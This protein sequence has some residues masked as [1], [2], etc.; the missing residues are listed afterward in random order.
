MH[1]SRRSYNIQANIEEK[2][3]NKTKIRKN[4]KTLNITFVSSFQKIT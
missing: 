3:K 2:G 4:D 1:I